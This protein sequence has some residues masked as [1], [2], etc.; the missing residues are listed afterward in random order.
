MKIDIVHLRTEEY[1]ESS[2]IPTIAL[3]TPTEDAYRRDLTINSLFYNIN[4]GEVE[5]LTGQ[6]LNDLSNQ[7]IRTPLPPLVTFTD[8]PLRA[9]RAI[10]F[11]CRFNFHI[12]YELLQACKHENVCKLLYEKVS[13]ERR[14]NEFD[15]IF[16][17]NQAIRGIYLLYHTGLL[18]AA[19]PSIQKLDKE[20]SFAYFTKDNVESK[21]KVDEQ[22][23]KRIYAEGCLNTLLVQRLMCQPTSD[24]SLS[25]APAV[26]SVMKGPFASPVL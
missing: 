14:R 11:A 13:Q 20:Y 22:L 5:D 1:S 24:Q 7:L 25:I 4:T 9:L 3:G 17:T 2:R 6:G 26:E 23:S 16:A 19:L 21:L 12:I 10:R 15:L 18:Q 8:D